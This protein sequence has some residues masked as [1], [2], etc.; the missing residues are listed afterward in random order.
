MSA[1][2]LEPLLDLPTLLLE[3][4]FDFLLFVLTHKRLP[5]GQKRVH[6]RVG[7]PTLEKM[8]Q[9]HLVPIDRRCQI[10]LKRRVVLPLL[11]P[12]IDE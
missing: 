4:V 3:D 12:L 11:R 8:N 6:V 5:L 10:K 9:H 1:R 7:F 2:V